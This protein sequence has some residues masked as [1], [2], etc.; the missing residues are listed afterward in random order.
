MSGSFAAPDG[1]VANTGAVTGA[2]NAHTALGDSEETSYVTLEA[3]E[4]VWCTLGNP[5]PALPA[6]AIVTRL[7]LY[8]TALGLSGGS[9]AKLQAILAGTGY[10]DNRTSVPTTTYRT[11]VAAYEVGDNDVGSASFTLRNAG[12]G[13]II[14][15]EASLV[16]W[17]AA[18]PTVDVT[19]PTG[20]L[21]EDNRPT[22]AWAATLDSTGGA[23]FSAEVAVFSDA[24]YGAGGFDPEDSSTSFRASIIG[25]ATTHQFEAPLDDD[26]YRAYVK[27]SQFPNFLELHE[28]D[29]A[30][31][32][33]VVDVPR[34]GLPTI[35][36]TAEPAAS[37]V[38]RVAL[39]L[40]DSAGET[41]TTAIQV[42]RKVGDNYEDIRTREGGGLVSSGSW[43]ETIYDYEAEVGEVETY[44]AR[45][46]HDF[47]AIESYSDWTADETVTLSPTS[48]S[49]IHPTLPSTSLNVVL[50]SFA[51]HARIARQSIRQPLGR[52]DAVVVSD[53]RSDE[54]GEITFRLPDD[55]TRDA[56]MALAGL[57]TPLLLRPAVGHHERSRW[58]VFGDE[59]V[60]RVIDQS[61]F[62]ERDGVY[63]WT[64]VAAPTGVIAEEW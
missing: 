45:A 32:Q 47:G 52:S 11:Y 59:Q 14:V 58:V 27:V 34:P 56:V 60:T 57:T 30:Y 53:V 26:T 64:E 5:S 35:T 4:L 33:F 40:D 16:V 61:W 44:R 36:A 2:A 17:Y 1:T 3:G 20:T 38:G 12:L 37:P 9:P 50:R 23:Q 51:G 62:V 46:I 13:T 22:I 28:S 15:T 19:A 6:G 39:A 63:P 41:T 55:A 29:W 49:V 21:D 10:T 8:V 43:P 7:D 24:Q 42:Q 18:K 31:E 25:Q 54:A 48:W